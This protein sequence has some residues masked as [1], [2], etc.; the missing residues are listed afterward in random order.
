MR[1]GECGR[2][3]RGRAASG[4]AV[5]AKIAGAAKG[6]RQD[7]LTGEQAIRATVE[8]AELEQGANRRVEKS[9][10]TETAPSSAATVDGA[11]T[12]RP[13]GCGARVD[14]AKRVNVSRRGG[15]GLC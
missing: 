12:G 10:R 1:D 11:W 8:G 6:R 3:K 7:E 9:R 14:G 5:V 4:S 13:A 2:T 15:A